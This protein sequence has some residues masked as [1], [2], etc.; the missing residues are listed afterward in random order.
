VSVAGDGTVV[1]T[2]LRH[3]RA[4]ISLRGTRIPT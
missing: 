2:T 4:P 3:R 1:A